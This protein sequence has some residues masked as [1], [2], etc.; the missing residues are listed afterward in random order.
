MGATCGVTGEGYGVDN[1]NI[2]DTVLKQ[3][4]DECGRK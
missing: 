1:I 3:T 4:G 2:I